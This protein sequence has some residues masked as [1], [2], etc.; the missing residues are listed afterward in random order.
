M[1]MA[2]KIKKNMKKNEPIIG[3][4][5]PGVS[6]EGMKLSHVQKQ[7]IA[8]INNLS[9]FQKHVVNDIVEFRTMEEVEKRYTNLAEWLGMCIASVLIEKFDLSIQETHDLYMDMLNEHLEVMKMIN[10][11]KTKLKKGESIDM[12]IREVEENLVNKAK[13]YLKEGK[14]KGVNNIKL[15][16]AADFPKVSKSLINT[17]FKKAKEEFEKEN[18][19]VEMTEEEE[20]LMNIIAPE[21]EIKEEI[22]EK[23]IKK[24]NLKIVS[25]S[26]KCEGL[27]AKYEKVNDIVK[28]LDVEGL[29]F[30]SEDEIE[31]Y[32]KQQI[33][34][35]N[36][37]IDEIKEV[38]MM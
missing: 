32:R 16:L 11:I 25:K 31:A 21:D 22:I 5:P 9:E 19:V 6:M 18:E 10:E 4:L 26:I 3:K 13:E 7:G 1:G 38:M 8:W 37:K 29:E 15:Q 23:E 17:T 24:T 14:I 34:A 12:K 30:K 33:E 35:I 27:Y 2:K 36:N 20:E 28:V